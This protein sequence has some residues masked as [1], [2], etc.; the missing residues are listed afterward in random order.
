MHHYDIYFLAIMLLFMLI[1]NNWFNKN[2]K[3]L[4]QLNL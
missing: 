1:F 2:S 3:F 4:F